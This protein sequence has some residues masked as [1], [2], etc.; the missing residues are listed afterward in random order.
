[1]DW[2]LMVFWGV[3]YR[4]IYSVLLL[5]FSVFRLVH[6]L[7]ETNPDEVSVFKNN[8][9]KVMKDILSRFKDLQFYTGLFEI[10]VVALDPHLVTAAAA[11]AAATT[12]DTYIVNRMLH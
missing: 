1:M 3:H 5:S 9:N 4:F 10:F 6:K 7:E 2:D 12:S 11:A 8:T